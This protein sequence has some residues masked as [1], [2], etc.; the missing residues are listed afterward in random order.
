[1][2]SVVINTETESNL[3]RRERVYL[4][5]LLDHSPS[6]REVRADKNSSQE[7]G[8]RNLELAP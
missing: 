6:L 2:L 5:I 3:W 4:V 8:T 7:P 1:L